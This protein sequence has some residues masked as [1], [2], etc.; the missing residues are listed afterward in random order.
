MI[1]VSIVCAGINARYVTFLAINDQL[2]R[3]Q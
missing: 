2:L 1:N 3:Q